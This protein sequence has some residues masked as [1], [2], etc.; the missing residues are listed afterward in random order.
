[1]KQA[2]GGIGMDNSIEFRKH[3]KSKPIKAVGGTEWMY[4]KGAM[5]R[6]RRVCVSVCVCVCVCVCACVHACVRA[7]VFVSVLGP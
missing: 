1:M 2:K 6:G 5:E 7:C 3:P 4:R